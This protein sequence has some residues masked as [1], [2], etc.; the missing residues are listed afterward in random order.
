MSPAPAMMDTTKH[1]SAM[2]TTTTTKTDSTMKK[3]TSMKM[4]KK[5]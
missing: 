3:D 1:D 4:G 5:P 2:S